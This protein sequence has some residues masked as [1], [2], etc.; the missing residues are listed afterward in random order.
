ML[1]WPRVA[2]PGSRANLGSS[3]CRGAS[4]RSARRLSEPSRRTRSLAVRKKQRQTFTLPTGRR[5]RRQLLEVIQFLPRQ[6]LELC[7]RS[8]GEW[9]WRATHS[10]CRTD[11]R[12][13]EPLWT[14]ESRLVDIVLHA[15]T[16]S[17]PCGRLLGVSTAPAVDRTAM[18]KNLSDSHGSCPAKVCLGL[19]GG[20]K[21]RP[22]RE[23]A[24]ST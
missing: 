16:V 1:R 24:A 4:S 5:A 22:I 17:T 7:R 6:F 2:L 9:G 8:D 13:A 12:A 21:G 18:K 3:S 23:G 14:I 11:A 15:A 19:P 20:V 10:P